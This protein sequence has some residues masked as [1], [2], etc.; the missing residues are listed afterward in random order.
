MTSKPTLVLV[1]GAWHRETMWKQF[2]QELPD[3]D[4]ARHRPDRRPRD[5][6][7]VAIGLAL[8]IA[9]MPVQGQSP[10]PPFPFGAP[11]SAAA[12]EPF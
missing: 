11:S 7:A 5:G 4:P 10:P 3:V 9:T 8:Y 6:V 2:I 1:H 12:P